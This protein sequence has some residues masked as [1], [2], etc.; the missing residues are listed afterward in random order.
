ID[1]SVLARIEYLI[2]TTRGAVPQ[3]DV[4]ALEQRLAE[5]GRTWADRVEDAASVKLGEI[6]A[7][8]RLRRLKPFPSAYQERT[9]PAQANADLNRI[10]AVLAGSPLEASLHP[11]EDGE[12][13]GL[14]LYRPDEPII[15][16]DILPILENL[17]L[18]IVAEE[19]FRI[20]SAENRA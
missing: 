10:E 15:L 2:A 3:I 11:R 17:G 14:R 8:A 12:G 9:S 16:S 20:D 7:R 18:R 13:S 5:A 1:E 6:E 19:P 4:A